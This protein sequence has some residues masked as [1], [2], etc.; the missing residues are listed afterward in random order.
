M[1]EEARKHVE[2]AITN[3]RE[4]KNCLGKA[5]NN[6]ENGMMRERLESQLTSIEGCLEECEG[7]ASGLSN[8]SQ[9]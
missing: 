7:I 8:L 5:T 4:V 1:N 6:A 2:H 3:L 9:K